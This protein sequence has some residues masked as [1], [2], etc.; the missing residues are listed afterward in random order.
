MKL[1]LALIV[2]LTL[3]PLCS[4]AQETE[5]AQ[6]LVIE[7]I[8]CRGNTATSCS[9]ILGYLYL[10]AGDRVDEEEIQ[11]AKFRLTTLPDFKKVDIYLERGS[12]RGNARLIIE[13]IEADPLFTEFA[14]GTSARGDSL[15]QMVGARIGHQNVFGTGKLIDLTVAGRLAIEDPVHEGIG[16]SLRYADPHLFDS[17]K[18][19]MLTGVSY[20]NARDENRH[21]S[22]SDVEALSAGITFGR[23]LWDFSY[24]TV[25][26]GY[27]P[28]LE[29]DSGNWQRSGLFDTDDDEDLNRHGVDVIYGWN[30]EDDYYFPTRGS[31]FHVGFGW[32]FGTSSEG[33][34][35][36]LQYRKT[37][38]TDSGTLWTVRVGGDPMTERRQSFNESQLLSFSLARPIAGDSLGDI[39]RG[40]WYIEPGYSQAGF[41]SFG[42]RIAEFGLKVGVRLE[43]ES[44]G[45]ID[46]YFIGS[47]EHLSG[48]RPQ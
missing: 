31:A 11:N 18:T 16:A 9:F 34:A 33:N 42:R 25:G 7:D 22:F 30:S 13:V 19:F 10:A 5:R 36:H 35:L 20:V 23:R 14:L 26:Y 47:V 12:A 48:S 1:A 40:R 8:Q 46:L 17:K 21:G 43:S 39:K 15:S 45:L 28:L 27:S 2:L 29:I 6:Q 37:W 32:Y 24:L 44:L 41:A 3:V 38:Q 4:A